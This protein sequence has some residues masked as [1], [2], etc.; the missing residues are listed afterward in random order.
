MV[1]R[2]AIGLPQQKGKRGVK[3]NVSCR[4]ASIQE[5]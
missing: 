1:V 5:V 3:D 2:I 4:E